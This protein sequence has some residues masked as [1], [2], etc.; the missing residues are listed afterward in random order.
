[1][2]GRRDLESSDGV[3]TF[4]KR[5][6]SD[7]SCGLGTVY[8]YASSRSSFCGQTAPEI[9][10][11]DSRCDELHSYCMIP[12]MHESILG[13]FSPWWIL[14]H[15][16]YV[17]GHFA[18]ILKSWTGLSKISNQNLKW[19]NP[20]PPSGNEVLTI[21][22]AGGMFYPTREMSGCGNCP[23]GTRPHAPRDT[24]HTLL[25][26]TQSIYVHYFAHHLHLVGLLSPASSI[27]V[28]SLNE[29]VYRICLFIWSEIACIGY[30]QP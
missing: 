17:V 29:L 2:T 5:Q 15:Y 6:S 25:L 19:T 9:I 28:K 4:R 8:G 14:G 16:P 7:I 12:I 30:H 23:G 11:N 13:H 22:T 24:G 21:I 1:M 10:Q 3:Q 18:P 27:E 26:K 20:I